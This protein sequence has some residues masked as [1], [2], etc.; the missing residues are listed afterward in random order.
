MNYEQKALKAHKLFMFFIKT[1]QY[2]FADRCLKLRSRF[3]EVAEK[4]ACP[5]LYD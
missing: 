2:D 5:W 4:Y 1:R 3:F